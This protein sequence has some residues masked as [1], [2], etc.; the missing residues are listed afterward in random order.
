MRKTGKKYWPGKDIEEPSIQSRTASIEA[1]IEKSALRDLE[2][3]KKR[4]KTTAA[5]IV[6][7]TKKGETK[8]R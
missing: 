3:G 6:K 4:I 7:S 8:V 1:R 5:S 2:N